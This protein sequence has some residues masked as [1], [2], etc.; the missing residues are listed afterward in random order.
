MSDAVRN[1]VPGMELGIVGCCAMQRL[2]GVLKGSRYG[3]YQTWFYEGRRVGA[4]GDFGDSWLFD[5][6]RDG[7]DDD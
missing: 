1:L 6:Q 4:G 3:S 5:A 7:G 2:F